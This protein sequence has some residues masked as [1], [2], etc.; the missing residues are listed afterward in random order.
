MTRRETARAEACGV[1]LSSSREGEG[2]YSVH[3]SSSSSRAEVRRERDR[4][5]RSP[6]G[7]YEQAC[8]KCW[9]LPPSFLH[10]GQDL[11]VYIMDKTLVACW[12]P[13]AVETVCKKG[14]EET[15]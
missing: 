13:K 9:S 11:P 12:T 2:I 5:V 10:N 14:E 8:K 6:G 1:W 4:Y 15:V 7:K 3:S